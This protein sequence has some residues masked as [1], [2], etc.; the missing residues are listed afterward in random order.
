MTRRVPFDQIDQPTL[1]RHVRASRPLAEELV[2]RAGLD[3]WSH[4]SARS[5][6]DGTFEVVVCADNSLPHLLTAEDVVRAL[7]EMR[8]V[9][10]PWR[11][12]PGDHPGAG[13]FQPLLLAR[14]PDAPVDP[15]QLRR[16]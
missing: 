2:A 13:F 15:G 6:A 11:P 14:V 8:R 9:V 3:A 12:G 4:L 16:P 10:A 5:L 7:G 1:P